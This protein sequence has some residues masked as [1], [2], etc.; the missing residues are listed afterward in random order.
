MHES[1]FRRAQEEAR[2]HEEEFVDTYKS[3]AKYSR[4]CILK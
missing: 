3:C 2:A 4:L 1:A